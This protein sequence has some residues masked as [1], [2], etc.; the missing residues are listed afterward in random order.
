MRAFEVDGARRLRELP[1]ETDHDSDASG[2]VFSFRAKISE[3]FG[4]VPSGVKT[5]VFVVGGSSSDLRDLAGD[6]LSAVTARRDRRIDF[7]RRIVARILFR[8][9][10]C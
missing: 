7:R 4:T 8:C 5:L 6:E 9:F 2:V 10:I 1:V 3:V